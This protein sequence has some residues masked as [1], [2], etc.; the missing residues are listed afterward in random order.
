MKELDFSHQIRGLTYPIEEDNASLLCAA[1]R[2]GGKK[3][4]ELEDSAFLDPKRRSFPVVDC[5]NVKAAV[6]TWG[7]YKGPMSFETFKTR[8]KARAKAIGCEDSLPDSWAKASEEEAQAKCKKDWEK[9]DKKELKRDDKKEKGEHEKD[10]VKD[11]Q[12][13]I[14]K[15]KKGK[16]SEKKS[17][18]VHDLQKDQEFDEADKEKYTKAEEEAQAKKGFLPPWLKD[19]KELNKDSDKEKEEHEKDAVK[20][21]KKQI[22]DLKKDE[23][24]DKKSEKK[25]KDKS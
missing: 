12:S 8:L 6:S 10:A 20:D 5:K 4:G 25:D 7:M 18:E 11:D 21:D 3:R 19:K 17:V 23:K 1:E 13:K 2:F 9:T 15:L 24:E 16:P 22:K 14:N